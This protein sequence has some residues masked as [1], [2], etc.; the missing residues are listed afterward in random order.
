MKNLSIW[1]IILNFNDQAHLAK[2]IDS[3]KKQNFP[4]TKI[5]VVDNNS[6]DNSPAII[7]KIKGIAR[8][9]LNQNLGYA[10]GNNLAL[11][12]AFADGA[13]LCILM[14]TD[15]EMK[16]YC[17][18]NMLDC[19][20]KERVNSC[21]LI[22]PSILLTK[23]ENKINSN[24]NALHIL[25]FGYCKDYN[26]NY[27]T[28]TKNR[29]II[30]VSGACMMIPKSYYDDIG[31]LD[32]NFFLYNEDQAYSWKGLLRGYKHYLSAN[33]EASHDYSFSKNKN[34][35]YYSES[36]RLSLLIMLYQVKTLVFLSPIFLLSECGILLT[37]LK[38]KWLSIKIR[39][40][41]RFLSQ[42]PVSLKKRSLI[43]STRKIKDHSL[44]KNFDK[45]LDFDAVKG[46]HINF[47]NFIF[48]RYMKL[49]KL[50][51]TNK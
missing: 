42:L 6:T 1:V 49:Y 47:F 38:E 29:Q 41:I 31:D 48:D 19:Y 18:K 15:L 51:N 37:A 13:D 27:Q 33:S 10:A 25:G 28:T 20:L 50:F 32:E 24:G 45:K 39:S 43:Q 26:E 12:Q 11:K 9:L 8:M 3:V 46:K 30:S 23:N 21:G 16:P 2:A 4:N 40:Y 7:K 34:K 44:I 5:L 17:L 22:Q 35:M 14:N 36:N